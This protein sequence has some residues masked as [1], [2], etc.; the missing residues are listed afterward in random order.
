M[1]AVQKGPEAVEDCYHMNQTAYRPS[2]RVTSPGWLPSGT[3]GLTRLEETST[4]LRPVRPSKEFVLNC[5]IKKGL[6]ARE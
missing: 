1:I 2:A 5:A 4:L 6:I 3:K